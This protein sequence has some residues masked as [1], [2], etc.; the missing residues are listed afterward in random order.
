LGSNVFR[1][2]HCPPA[3][4]PPSIPGSGFGTSSLDDAE[5]PKLLS[6]CPSQARH[7]KKLI[8]EVGF[9]FREIT[10]EG[11]EEVGGRNHSW[12]KLSIAPPKAPVY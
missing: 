4:L 7:R 9:L 10:F 11:R 8:T 6:A 1:S 12:Q 3:N 2:K 5:D